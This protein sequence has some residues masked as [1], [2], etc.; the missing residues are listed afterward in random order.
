MPSNASFERSTSHPTPARPMLS[1][2]LTPPQQHRSVTLSPSQSLKVQA[3]SDE[4]D[5]QMAPSRAVHPTQYL[6]SRQWVKRSQPVS[7]ISIDADGSSS[8]SQALTKL[9]LLKQAAIIHNLP[10]AIL[11]DPT[12]KGALDE[13]A[14][15]NNASLQNSISGSFSSTDLRD[16]TDSEIRRRPRR[17][18]SSADNLGHITDILPVGAAFDP[19][20]QQKIHD[21]L[22]SLIVESPRASTEPQPPVRIEPP[23]VHSPT[24]RPE[25]PVHDVR[26][27][28]SRLASVRAAKDPSQWSASSTTL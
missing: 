4:S 20:L 24:S 18:G 11:P 9:Q 26:P 10:P 14:L 27:S 8:V 21:V 15:R 1:E 5:G 25:S 12:N 28:K 19:Q 13:A 22:V 17:G 7:L 2:T 3:P 23:V 6:L 16:R